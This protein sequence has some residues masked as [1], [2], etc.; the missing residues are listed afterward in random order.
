MIDAVTSRQ[1]DASDL[2]SITPVPV[3]CPFDPHLFFDTI[4]STIPCWPAPACP[5]SLGRWCTMS[6]AWQTLGIQEEKESRVCGRAPV[7]VCDTT[8]SLLGWI[9]WYKVASCWRLTLTV[10][11]CRILSPRTVCVCLGIASDMWGYTI[12]GEQGLLVL[13]QASH[14]WPYLKSPPPPSPQP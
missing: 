8:Q 6:S 1:K 11:W 5:L 13:V 4:S 14:P 10:T 12:Q 3:T 7:G 9:C 2:W